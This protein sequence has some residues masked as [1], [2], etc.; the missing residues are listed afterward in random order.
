MQAFWVT[1]SVNEYESK[2]QQRL[3]P[4]YMIL[5]SMYYKKADLQ[6]NE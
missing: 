3:R 5:H 2:K 1:E 6:Y 4:W